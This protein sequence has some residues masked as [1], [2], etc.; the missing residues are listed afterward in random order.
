M[1]TIDPTTGQQVTVGQGLGAVGDLASIGGAI[2]NPTAGSVIGA[3]GSLDKLYN[4]VATDT[5]SQTLPSALGGAIGAAGDITG[6][7]GAIENPSNPNADVGAAIDA[8]KLASTIANLSASEGASA[9]G[10]AA[11]STA[12]TAAGS[13]LGAVLGGVSAGTGAIYAGYELGNYLTA[14]DVANIYKN[15]AP[16][17]ASEAAQTLASADLPASYLPVL[18]SQIGAPGSEILASAEAAGFSADQIN[19][20]MQATADLVPAEAELTAGSSGGG[21]S[22]G[23]GALRGSV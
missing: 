10:S 20:I 1:P 8:T 22:V 3:A 6:I 16:Q 23:I 21:G 2:E 14:N 9:A 11:T 4:T 18:E 13:S 19:A 7:V 12:G 5:G 17:Q 15:Y